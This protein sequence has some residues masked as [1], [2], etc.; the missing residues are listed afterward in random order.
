MVMEEQIVYEI[1]REVALQSIVSSNFGSPHTRE[2]GRIS[3]YVLQCTEL[4]T[5]WVLYLFV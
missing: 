1:L 2:K 5:M 4:G 3:E